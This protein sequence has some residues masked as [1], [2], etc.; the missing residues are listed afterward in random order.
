[1]QG[2]GAIYLRQSHFVSFTVK[3]P[4]FILGA[5]FLWL[6]LAEAYAG[7][8]EEEPQVRDLTTDSMA[9]V[10]SAEDIKK[11][12]VDNAFSLE[13]NADTQDVGTEKNES[14]ENID[15]EEGSIPAEPFYS[16][17]GDGQN[18]SKAL[19]VRRHTQNI[20]SVDSPTIDGGLISAPE[21]V[22]ALEAGYRLEN[23]ADVMDISSVERLFILSKVNSIFEENFFYNAAKWLC[24]LRQ[25]SILYRDK[26]TQNI[27]L[28]ASTWFNEA[29]KTVYARNKIAQS[30][31]ASHSKNTRPKNRSKRHRGGAHG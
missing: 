15:H 13:E 24:S 6:I 14:T 25:M 9:V 7:Q 5:L 10:L 12:G 3:V 23:G 19:E 4:F 8:N 26:L 18:H 31:I 27:K 30:H 22:D 17:V 2:L 11:G 21:L 16:K 20:G 28:I 1:M 29:S